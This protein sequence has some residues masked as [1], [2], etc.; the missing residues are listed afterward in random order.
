MHSST[1]CIS[2]PGV[3]GASGQGGVSSG[4]RAACTCRARGARAGRQPAWLRVGDK[5]SIPCRRLTS[6]TVSRGNLAFV[7]AMSRPAPCAWCVRCRRCKQRQPASSLL[8]RGRGTSQAPR[9]GPAQ[10]VS[11]GNHLP[12]GGLKRRPGAESRR[13]AGSCGRCGAGAAGRGLLLRL[14]EQ[15]NSPHGQ[16]PE[17]TAHVQKPNHGLLAALAAGG[18]LSRLAAPLW[19]VR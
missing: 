11:S 18:C 7:T 13:P 9:A 14:L 1:P 8:G 6:L 17:A 4:S 2:H 12:S 3:H 19:I 15:G 10:H 5:C 16:T